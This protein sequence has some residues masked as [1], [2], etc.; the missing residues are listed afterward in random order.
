MSFTV[1]RLFDGWRP[2]LAR[3][4]R[5]LRALLTPGEGPEPHDYPFAP[6]DVAQLQRLTAHDRPDA[7]DDQS[8]RDLLLDRYSEQLSLETSIFGRQAL[9]RRLRN[10]A[11]DE[12]AVL[13][14][15]RI[16]TL[17]ADRA[18]LDGLHRTLRP[19]RHADIE[20]AGLLF[21]PALPVPEQPGWLRMWFLIPLMLLASI[22][23]AL[24]LSPAAWTGTAIAMY[25]LVGPQMRYRERMEALRRLTLA[26]QMMLR[27][28]S[29][30][31]GSA[32]PLAG[33][34]TGRGAQ[35]GRINRGL[36]RPPGVELVPGVK[37]YGD[38]F[39]LGNVRHYF[40]SSRLVFGQRDF[41]R[42]CYELCANLEADV[43]LARHLLA[44]PAWCW[45]QRSSARSL[46]LEGGV[47]P[48]VD[49]AS[50]LSIAL[51]G[52]GA[53]LSGQNGVGKST[54]LRTLGLNLAAAR[55]FGFCYARRASLPAL[56]VAASMQNEDS[57][58]GGESLYV[59][60]LRRARELLAAAQDGRDAIYLVDEIFRGTNHM[61][62][63]A[64]AAAVLDVL[65]GH[66]LVIVSSHNLILAPL[67]RHRLDP[68]CIA[69]GGDGALALAG[70]VLAETNGVALLSRHGFGAQV[71]Q[72]A[73]RVAR[74]LGQYLAEPADCGQ[75]LG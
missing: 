8:W 48:L 27:V 56:P 7:L 43:A 71:E 34:F 25:L 14:R 46:A 22:A 4:S 31:D 21:D 16:E 75:V 50:A 55:A 70:G 20:V 3:F 36:A 6:T 38:W 35:A 51:D 37:E 64:A 49:G 63:V 68:Y 29:L 13:R 26:L 32:H 44:T 73:A 12:E 67:L 69:R 30:L 28:C 61:E 62:S 42:A 59:S 40:E 18:R 74:W 52:K 9:Y 2:L 15:A 47:H 57:L 17:L 66:G 53:F 39:M 23:A 41:L 24:L 65:A 54:F 33:D 60:E 11:S 19:L 45:A 72:R 1:F 58:L 10:G 5:Q